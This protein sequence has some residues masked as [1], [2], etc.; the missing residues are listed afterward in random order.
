[1]DRN[2]IPTR[3]G[4]LWMGGSPNY[5]TDAE[6]LD[7]DLNVNATFD[8]PW[9]DPFGAG[10]YIRHVLSDSDNELDDEDTAERTRAVASFIAGALTMGWRV[11]VHC[12]MGLNRSGVVVA[13]ALMYLGMTSDD[14]IALIREHRKARGSFNLPALFNRHFERWLLSEDGSENTTPT[15]AELETA[16]ADSVV[17]NR[18]RFG[19]DRDCAARTSRG[20]EVCNCD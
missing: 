3:A 6:L 16:F 5:V 2:L 19:H 10:V 1:M 17:M 8:Q 13:R 18:D 4:E 7:F 11:H 9:P 15:A 14:A 12:T 20:R